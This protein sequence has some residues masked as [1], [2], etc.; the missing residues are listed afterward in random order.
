M[1]PKQNVEHEATYED[2]RVAWKLVEGKKI[3]GGWPLARG[4]KNPVVKG[5]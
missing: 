1:F 5:A 2:M 4:G 3:R